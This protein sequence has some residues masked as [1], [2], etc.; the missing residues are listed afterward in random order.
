MNLSDFEKKLISALSE[1]LPLV[2]RPYAVLAERLGTTEE[3]IIEGIKSLQKRGI[4]RRLGGTLRHNRAGIEGNVMVAWEVP[5]SRVE[6]VGRYCTRLPFITHCYLRRTY[7]DWPYNFYT[8]I[9]AESEE[10]C[11][12]M[13]EKL[14][15]ELGLKDYILLFT[16]KEVVRRMR[17]YFAEE[18]KS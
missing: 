17:R 8:M 1:G 9:H 11:R 10:E 6:E 5:P 4:I 2:S 15:Y 14:A 13:V 18:L 12:K 7:P 3:S 16:E